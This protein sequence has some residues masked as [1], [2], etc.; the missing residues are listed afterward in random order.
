MSTTDYVH[1]YSPLETARLADQAGTL[2]ELLHADTRYP[3]GSKVLEPGCAVG[4]QTVLLARNS[5]LASFTSVDISPE[6]LLQAQRRA[7]RAGLGNVHF[8]VADIYALPFPRAH[9]DHVFVCFLLEHLPDPSG[10]LAAVRRVLK[11]GGTITVIEGDHGSAQ[12]YPDSEDARAAVGALIELQRRAGGDALIGR[13]LYPLLDDAGFRDVAVSPRLV[14][15]DASRPDLVDG[16]TRK[17][18][19]AMVDGVRDEALAAGLI[20]AARFDAG[21]RDLH[22][23]ADEG[24]FSYTFFKAV[25]VNPSAVTLPSQ[26]L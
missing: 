9:F 24:T 26:L 6:S 1:G 3:P 4:A 2:T 16:F 12:A 25:A 7:Q 15:T 22:R 14:Y 18:F 21:I 20:D 17:T 5:P 11:P 23:A 19:T 8:Q 13:R 10:A